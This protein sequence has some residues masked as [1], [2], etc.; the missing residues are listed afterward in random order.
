MCNIL[1]TRAMTYNLRSQKDFVRHCVN[2]RRYGLYSKI[3][4]APKVWD[5][6]LSEIKNVYFLI[7]FNT[8]IRK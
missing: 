7:M 2:T 3:S 1:K 8:E 4:L 6:V 5:M